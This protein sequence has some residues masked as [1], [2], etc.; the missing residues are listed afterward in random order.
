MERV[1]KQTLQ[2][3]YTHT[4]T[5]RVWALLFIALIVLGTCAELAIPLLQQTFFTLLSEGNIT[6]DT[7][8]HLFT[9]LF[10][11]A[12]VYGIVWLSS[13]LSEVINNVYKNRIMKELSVTAYQYLMG[14]G[15]D[16]FQNN[17]TGSLVKKVRNFV[18]AYDRI[19]SVL[20]WQAIPI[21]LTVI[22]TSIVLFS[23]NILLGSAVLIFAIVMTVFNY[24]FS[25]YKLRYDEQRTKA[26]TDWT[27]ALADTISNQSNI[28][29]FN[30]TNTEV[31]RYEAISEKVKQLNIRTWNLGD[32]N[33]GIQMFF[34][35]GLEIGLMYVGI[36]LWKQG[37]FY[38]GDFIL[39]QGYI[40]L[41]ARN[42]WGIGRVMRDYYEAI[43]DA[44]EMTTILCEP[45]AIQ[46]KPHAKKLSVKK[47]I[48]TF[49][50]VSF[51]YTKSKKVIDRLS[52]TIKPKERVAFVGSSGAGK[53]TITKLLMRM[54]DVSE[55]SILI[56]G[57]PI[58]DVTQESL[59]KHI[60]VVP[61]TSI[62]FH[63]TIFENI[64]YGKPSA[65]KEEVIHAAK[66]ANCHGFITKMKD[67]YDTYVGERGVKLSGGER[68]RVAIARAI[69]KNSPILILDE[70]T[71]SLDSESE[72]MIQ[73]ALEH[74]MKNK[75]VIVIAHRLST[76]MQMDRIIVL[77]K[78][79]VGE[80]GSHKELLQKRNGVYRKLWKLQVGGFIT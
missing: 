35:L 77:D 32:L 40:V 3:Y 30:G 75:T 14:H 24:W 66:L 10:M 26:Y 71:A 15:E 48:I 73:D 23:K 7:I 45:Q 65:T 72:K 46:D 2:I 74:L 21:V 78:G 11:I 38:V 54:H 67:G 69:L 49:D 34:I 27:G 51:Y 29:L 64:Q 56:D 76:I 5:Y 19:A 37:S 31:K 41:L 47:G 8:H 36:V 17:F 61:Q 1:T 57:Q 80:D 63:R 25:L 62:L 6:N 13:R 58:T 16:F 60:S 20:T 55:G 28:K 70:A 53:S 59:W 50:S 18:D 52:L 44:N 42:F 39:V 22:V 9:T 4:Q 43:A 33:A 12:S 79:R 68:Q